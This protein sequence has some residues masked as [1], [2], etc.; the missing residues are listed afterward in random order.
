MGDRTRHRDEI[1]LPMSRQ[2][3]ADYLA[4]SSETVSRMLTK[5]ENTSAIALRTTRSI[6]LRDRAGLEQMVI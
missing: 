4:L 6:V 5:L 1:G 3:I 2:D